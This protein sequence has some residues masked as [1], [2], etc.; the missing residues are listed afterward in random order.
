M[1][2]VADES[3]DRQIVERL[4]LEGHSVSYVVDID[5]GLST[6]DVFE[7]ANQE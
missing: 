1:N 2:F 5:A 3:V 4:R 6:G 7:M